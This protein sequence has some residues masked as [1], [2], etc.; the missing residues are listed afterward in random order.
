MKETTAF[1]SYKFSP[2]SPHRERRHGNNVKSLPEQAPVCNNTLVKL[3][4]SSHCVQHSTD[5]VQ[6][7]M[8]AHAG[9]QWS[10]LS[11]QR[12]PSKQVIVTCFESDIT[13]TETW[14]ARVFPAVWTAW[15]NKL[16]LLNPVA[17][18]NTGKNDRRHLTEPKP[19]TIFH[20]QTLK[21]QKT[22]SHTAEG[23]HG[24]RKRKIRLR[25]DRSVCGGSKGE[26]NMQEAL[27]SINTAW[28]GRHLWSRRGQ[29]P[30][31]DLDASRQLPNQLWKQQKNL[32]DNSLI[33][34]V[35]QD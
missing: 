3:Q 4:S 23:D 9:Q 25:E 31:L 5:I 18:M 30:L 17:G 11:R 7:Q 10:P 14:A 2:W 21:G 8:N 19:M 22:Q 1:L 24:D 12:N 27:P 16:F 32:N 28:P 26:G 6:T 33:I 15:L 35:I 20:R 29:T 13:Q 34:K